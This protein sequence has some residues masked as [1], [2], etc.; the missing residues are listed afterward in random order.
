[1]YRWGMGDTADSQSILDSTINQA[2]T[3]V[4][5][6]GGWMLALLVGVGFLVWRAGR[7]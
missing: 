7:R 5:S 6:A 3:R 1:M 4:T 2:T